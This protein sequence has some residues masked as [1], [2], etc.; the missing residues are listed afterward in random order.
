MKNETYYNNDK[1]NTISKAEARKIRPG[2][3]KDELMNLCRRFI[4]ENEISCAEAV[5]QM[6][7]VSNNSLEFIEDIC[8]LIGYKGEI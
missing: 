6:E 2:Y 8:E 1:I 5:H 3:Y 7:C 4:D